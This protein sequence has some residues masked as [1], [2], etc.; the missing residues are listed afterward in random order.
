LPN[1]KNK[2]LKA[3]NRVRKNLVDAVL[4]D[5]QVVK[6]LCKVHFR[7]D[8]GNETCAGCPLADMN[9]QP[10]LMHAPPTD[11][12]MGSALRVI[13]AYPSGYFGPGARKYF[14]ITGL[15]EWNR[16]QYWKR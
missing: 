12:M 2:S 5:A 8:H 9:M 16:K 7:E 11:E 3:L 4:T 10:C 6:P 1:L 14:G 13:E 15:I